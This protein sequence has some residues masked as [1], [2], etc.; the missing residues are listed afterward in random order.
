[1]VDNSSSVTF[2]NAKEK[3]LELYKKINSNAA[4]QDKFDVQSYQFDT[5]FEPSSTF[6]FKGTQTNIEV[7]AKNLKSIY[8]NVI[9]RP[10]LLLMEIR[11]RE[12]IMSIVLMPSIKCI[13]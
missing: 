13:H 9:S 11:L 6:N 2:L 4:I 12:M 10:L 8:R 1:M 5:D 7:I 3:A